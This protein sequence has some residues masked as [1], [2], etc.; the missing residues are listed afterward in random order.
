MSDE[1][2]SV[3]VD[4]LLARFITSSGW[5]RKSDQTVKQDAF[6]PYPYPDLSVT[7]HKGLSNDQL[8]RVGQAIAEARPATLYGRADVT[9]QQVRGHRLQVEARPVP[10]NLNHA[11]IIGWPP[12]KP[13]Q[14]S[15]AQELAAVASYVSKPTPPV[16]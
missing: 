13:S 16:S 5:I 6:V 4:E 11:T 2:S 3:A 15:F 9:A 1:A 10:E 12:D 7:R 8:W 14:K